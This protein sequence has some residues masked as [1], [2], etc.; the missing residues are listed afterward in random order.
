M[1]RIGELSRRSGVSVD[2]LRAWERRYG[3]LEPRRTGGGF[4]L[5]GD[6]DVARVQRMRAHLAAGLSAGQAAELARAT[7]AE[8][9]RAS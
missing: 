9:P 6:E 7:P 4:R 2:V 5:Y 1:L 8:A 3:L